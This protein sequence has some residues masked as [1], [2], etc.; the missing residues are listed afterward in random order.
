[1]LDHLIYYQ[2]FLTLTGVTATILATTSLKCGSGQL[3]PIVSTR[4]KEPM[5]KIFKLIIR[6]NL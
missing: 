2:V 3:D 4:I 1:M 5:P 6:Q